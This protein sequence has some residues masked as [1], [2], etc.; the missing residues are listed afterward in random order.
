VLLLAALATVVLWPV[1]AFTRDVVFFGVA[2]AAVN[3]LMSGVFAVSFSALSSSTD[4]A[5]CGRVMSFAYLPVNLGS[6]VGPTIGSV[7][8][9]ASVLA[10]FPVAA[11]F[12]A[13]GVLAL[14]V[15]RGQ[16]TSRAAVPA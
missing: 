11:A 7:V 9:H 1:P 12:T 3:G 10:V 14:I 4:D 16:K 15:A 13:V 2:Y 6:V 5:T 8:T